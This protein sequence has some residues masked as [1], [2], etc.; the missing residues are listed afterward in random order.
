MHY[1]LVPSRLSGLRGRVLPE[2]QRRSS[3]ISTLRR[4]LEPPP[5]SLLVLTYVLR[6]DFKWNVM[7]TTKVNSDY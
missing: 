5:R 1:A 6:K 4:E 7:R 3:R 2:K